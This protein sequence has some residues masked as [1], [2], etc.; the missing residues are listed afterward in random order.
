MRMI[1]TNGQSVRVMCLTMGGDTNYDEHINGFHYYKSLH[2][3]YNF[4]WSSQIR[5]YVVSIWGFNLNCF[6]LILRY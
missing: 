2:N 4:I 5:R 6:L 1:E 3:S